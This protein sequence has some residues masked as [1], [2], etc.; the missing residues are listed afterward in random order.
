M[1]R[2][3]CLGTSQFVRTRIRPQS[4]RCAPELQIFEP[5]STQVS[6]S[7]SARV[8]APAMSEPLV[9]SDIISTNTRSPLSMAVMYEVDPCGDSARRRTSAR[10][11]GLGEEAMGGVAP[12]LPVGVRL[13][14]HGLTYRP[15]M[16]QPESTRRASSRR[17]LGSDT[18]LGVPNDW[19]KRLT[20]NSSTIQR[21]S[22]TAGRLAAS[23]PRRRSSTSS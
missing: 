21:T 12:Q 20:R 14:F 1:L 23:A 19:A 7:R 22:K 4:L 17:I 5:L 3:R 18:G 11:A 13:Q 9:G 8:R 15:G 16:S 10:G 6:P 2:P